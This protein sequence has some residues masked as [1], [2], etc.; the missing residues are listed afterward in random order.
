ML[1][2]IHALQSSER[3]TLKWKI[4]RFPYP[5]LPYPTLPYPT[6]AGG[7]GGGGGGGAAA[8][9]NTRLPGKIVAV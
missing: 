1:R 5:T 8:N 3:S 9:K 7:G 2:S 6:L 4:Q